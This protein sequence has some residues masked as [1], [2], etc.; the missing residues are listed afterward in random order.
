M[1]QR[2][3]VEVDIDA[4]TLL[5]DSN[6]TAGGP[7]ILKC[8]ESDVYWSEELTTPPDRGNE[9]K[10]IFL[11]TKYRPGAICMSTFSTFIKSSLVR[12]AI[13]I[14]FSTSLFI[15]HRK[16]RNQLGK[17][18]ARKKNCGTNE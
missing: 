7:R 16:E 11:T 1:H 10:L 14:F 5:Y 18:I 8:G 15:A 6:V 3:E 13:V 2:R 4:Q 17:N 12:N 9:K